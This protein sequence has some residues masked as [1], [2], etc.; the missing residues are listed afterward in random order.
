[1]P[2]DVRRFGVGHRR[3]QGPEGSVG[4]DGQVVYGDG[5]GV[6][7]E[8]AFA[9]NARLEPHESPNSTWLLVIEGGGWVQV[10]EER[11]RVAAGEAVAWPAGIVHAAWTEQSHMRAVQVELSGPD[12]AA[13]RGVLEGR[14]RLIGPGEGRVVDRGT[15]RLADR[16]RDLDGV[17]REG[18]PL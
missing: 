15:G 9:R 11:R 5:R 3:P 8:L 4:V 6:I 16:P 10:G 17:D 13:V 7:S 18:E 12:D 14:A 1:M 2:I